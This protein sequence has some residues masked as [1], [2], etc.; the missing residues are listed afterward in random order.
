MLTRIYWLRQFDNGAR[1]GIMPRPRGGDW[2]EDEIINF[3]KQK[4][5]HIASLLER[6]EIIELGLT[7]EEAIC[8]KHE[9][10]FLH[11]PIKDR[12]IPSHPNEFIKLLSK[13]IDE[14]ATVVIHCRMGI[15]RSSIIAG[16]VLLMNG[17]IA[18][19]VFEYISRARG[20][21]V[22]D[23][24]DQIKWLKAREGL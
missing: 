11:F 21:K 22:P 23:T 2:L 13:K 1:I 15:G 5:T 19:E 16:S 3:R 9:I 17:Y 8:A 20:L 10:E 18:D 4:V 24:E 6:E 7:Q 12:G 14:G